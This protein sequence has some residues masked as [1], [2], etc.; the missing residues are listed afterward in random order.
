[1][2]NPNY[3]GPFGNT[4]LHSAVAN[5]DIE[6]VERLLA[7]GADP[8]IINRYGKTPVDE[9]VILGYVSICDLLLRRAP[10]SRFRAANRAS[11]IASDGSVR[12]GHAPSFD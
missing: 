3:Q 2:E 1:M 6:E 8:T 7:A 10:A 5:G 9:A 4:L 12:H 11:T